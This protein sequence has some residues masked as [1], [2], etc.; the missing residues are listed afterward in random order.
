MTID[1]KSLFVAAV[2]ALASVASADAKTVYPFTFA[3]QEGIVAEVEKP[4]RQELCLNGYWD[5][6]PVKT[7]KDYRQG[8]GVAPE[9]PEP[10]A[11][12]WVS[13]TLKVP[14]PWN[15]N[16]YAYRNLEGPDHRNYPSYPKEW[17]DILMG[18]LRKEVTVPAD[19]AGEEIR[20]YFEA[21]A[22]EATV[23]VNGHEAGHNFDLFLPFTVDVTDYV[24]P[25]E[26][27]EILVGVRSQKLFEDDSTVGRRIVPAGSMWG[28]HIN[29]I[30][31]DVYLLAVP[32]VS[33][34]DVYVRPLVG[35]DLLEVDVELTNA[36]PKKVEINL[37]GE[38]KEWINKAG[39]DINS[40]P[41]PKW[42]LGETSLT[43]PAQ[44]VAIPAGGSVKVTL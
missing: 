21:V 6:Q 28:Y 17:D 35:R 11:D 41:A 29:G 42:T 7:P 1:I 14:S 27:A 39:T 13:H 44:K 24:K 2:A 10:K 12:A 33:I 23:Y 22:G 19:W 5:F 43:I 31:Q 25:G 38:A 15:I 18:W 16:S 26:K 37:S 8:A 34:S 3:P 4:Y 40:A 32:K 30:W 9:L 36:T 20:L